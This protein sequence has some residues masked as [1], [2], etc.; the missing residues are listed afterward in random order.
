MV[1]KKSTTKKT[2]TATS[3]AFTVTL[4]LARVTKNT[5]R[6]ETDDEDAPINPLYVKQSAFDKE[7]SSI[8]VTVNPS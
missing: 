8:T 6:F 7:P 3:K 1:A 5:Y 2:T 4:D